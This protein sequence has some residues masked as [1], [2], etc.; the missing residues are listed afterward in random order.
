[1][2][3]QQDAKRAQNYM[4]KGPTCAGCNNMQS[5][6]VLPAW[7]RQQNLDDEENGRELS[8]NIG[9]HGIEKN[10][11]CGIGGFAVKKQGCCDLW[12]RKS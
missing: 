4:P 6:K 11:R 10:L 5:D 2:S 9:V 8:W 12:S 3:K 1:M 7:M